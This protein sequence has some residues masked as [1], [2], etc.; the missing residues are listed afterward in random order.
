MRLATVTALTV[1]P[2]LLTLIVAPAIK[3]FPVRVMGTLVP[4]LPLVGLIEISVGGKALILK[5]TAPLVPP[6]VVTVTFAAPSA[7]V[8]PMV[9]VAVI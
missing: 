8:A 7:A 1:T 6:A 5:V 2:G 9:K 3:L 4:G